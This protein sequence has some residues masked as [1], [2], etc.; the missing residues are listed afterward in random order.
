VKLSSA[1]AVS[2]PTAG[3]FSGL[4]GPTPHECAD[5]ARERASAEPGLR[6]PCSQPAHAAG[7]R[8]P[9]G[10][11]LQ[12]PARA[13]P[14]AA[15]RP[16]WRGP[17][18][19][20]EGDCGVGALQPAPAAATA[21]APAAT[22]SAPAVLRPPPRRPHPV[23]SCA[24]GAVSARPQPE[25]AR[26]RAA[27]RGG[28]RGTVGM[29]ARGE[30]HASSDGRALGRSARRRAGGY[31]VEVA[32]RELRA[33]RARRELTRRVRVRVGCQFLVATAAAAYAAAGHV[34][35]ARGA[36]VGR[37]HGRRR[38]AREERHHVAAVPLPRHGSASKRPA[39]R[40]SGLSAAHVRA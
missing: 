9:P 37:D 40:A 39:V 27:A 36:L 33:V 5:A 12:R 19:A 1:P 20:P 15:G 14:V 29:G 21:P 25:R 32:Q 26:R 35:E 24:H 11:G 28:A 23:A 17:H 8:R 34:R 4:S 31:P 38:L 16:A 22:A 30:G 13:R 2:S 3:S 10:G 6:Q 18:F 7:P